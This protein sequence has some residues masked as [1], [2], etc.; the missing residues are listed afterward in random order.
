MAAMRTLQ[1]M[2]CLA[3]LLAACATPGSVS[4]APKPSYVETMKRDLAAILPTLSSPWVKTTLGRVVELPSRAPRTLWVDKD[5][6]RAVSDADYQKLS[7]ADRKGLVRE[8]EDDEFY[9]AKYSSPVAYARLL[10][11]A[12]AAGLD[13]M[14]GKKVVDFG[15]G[16]IGQLQLFAKDGAHAVGVDPNRTD[17]ALYTSPDDLAFP[18]GS[19]QLVTGRW[20]A[21]TAA[22]AQVGG[23][24]DVFM[25]KNTLKK[26]YVRP[27][28][29]AGQTVD[30]KKLIKLGDDQSTF[31]PALHQA[32]RPGALVILYNICPA[33]SKGP[34]YLPWAD[35]RSP[36][37]R[38]EWAKAGFAIVSFDVDDT[39]RVREMGRLMGWDKEEGM[40]LKDDLFAWYTVARRNP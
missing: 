10:E 23:D 19:V 1:P 11:V 3:F 27:E 20:P 8:V 14:S 36:F 17:A 12:A 38:E 40:N 29:P 34:E 6:S 24:I 13:G 35:G 2:T 33:P 26:G 21:E 39:E 5:H 31:L 18:P 32:T 22:R 4:K 25:S 30:P 16:D 9:Y 7:E 28:P 37:T 15:Y